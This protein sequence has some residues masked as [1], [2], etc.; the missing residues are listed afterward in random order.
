MDKLILSIIIISFI[1]L[2]LVLIS[3]YSLKEL[4]KTKSE[5]KSKV[6]SENSYYKLIPGKK[7]VIRNYGLTFKSEKHDFKVDYEVD[8]I[9]V[10]EKSVK[11]SAFNFETDDDMAKD[12]Q[13]K[14]MIINFFKNTWINKNKVEVLLDE[15]GTRDKKLNEILNQ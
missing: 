5:L 8:I 2:I 11:V 3:I 13:Y 1:C 10:S 15:N 6:D 7:G 14:N 4:I 12:P 9:E